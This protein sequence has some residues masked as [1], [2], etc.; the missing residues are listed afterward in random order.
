MITNVDH[1]F[2]QGNYTCRYEDKEATVIVRRRT[3]EEL[4]RLPRQEGSSSAYLLQTPDD[5]GLSHYHHS[6][7]CLIFF[8]L[9]LLW[10]LK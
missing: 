9:L 1:R 5:T 4:H 3:K 8:F 6:H 10:S 2:S 7:L